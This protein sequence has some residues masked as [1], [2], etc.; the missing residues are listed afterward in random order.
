MHESE[1][2]DY[3]LAEIMTSYN[4]KGKLRLLTALKN[5]EKLPGA[6]FDLNLVFGIRYA[7]ELSESFTTNETK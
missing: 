3:D 5:L 6:I 2:S 1:E 4:I 7:T